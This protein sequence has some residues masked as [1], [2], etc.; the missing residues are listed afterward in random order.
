MINDVSTFCKHYHDK[1]KIK[2][3][4][5]AYNKI[6]QFILLKRENLSF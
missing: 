6:I 5:N 4:T 1:L 3:Y 2:I